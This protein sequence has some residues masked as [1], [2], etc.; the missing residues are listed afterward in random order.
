LILNK[1][2][3]TTEPKF[4]SDLL[5]KELSNNVNVFNSMQLIDFYLNYTSVNANQK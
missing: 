2:A 1:A 3:E 4:L 5:G